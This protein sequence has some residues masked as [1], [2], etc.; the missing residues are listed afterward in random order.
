MC[1]QIRRLQIE[2]KSSLHLG[3]LHNGPQRSKQR[4]SQLAQAEFKSGLPKYTPTGEGLTGLCN[5]VSN[6]SPL[7]ADTSPSL[8]GKTQGN[9]DTRIACTSVEATTANKES[10]G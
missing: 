10:K 9:S 2:Q 7:F 5:K 4:Q 3:L 8:P 6:T 1:E